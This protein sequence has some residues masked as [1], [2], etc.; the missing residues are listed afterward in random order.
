V[1]LLTSLRNS[2]TL[3]TTARTTTARARRRA[4]SICITADSTTLRHSAHLPN[5]ALAASMGT[6]QLPAR[7]GRVGRSADSR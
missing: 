3:K 1:T 6:A 4:S 5:S 2:K 7:R